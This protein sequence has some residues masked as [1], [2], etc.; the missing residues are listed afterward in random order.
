MS[1]GPK[2]A[3]DGNADMTNRNRIQGRLAEAEGKASATGNRAMDRDARTHPD[4]RAGKSGVARVTDEQLTLGDL[5]S[6][7][8]Q[9]HRRHREVPYPIAEVSRGRS[10]PRPVATDGEWLTALSGKGWW[11]RSQSPPMQEGL[12][13]AWFKGQGLIGL[14][15]QYVR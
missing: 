5:R 2:E 4:R 1:R 13:L 12:S 15:E 14:L 9:Q 3:D 8:R 7:A 10:S 6:R 11:R